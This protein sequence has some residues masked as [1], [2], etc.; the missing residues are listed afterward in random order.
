M[1]DSLKAV[2][3]ELVLTSVKDLKSKQFKVDRVI[4]AT[5]LD[6]E[7]AYPLSKNHRDI[8]EVFSYAENCFLNNQAFHDMG[9]R[10]QR[11]PFYWKERDFQDG[12]Y[13][14]YLSDYLDISYQ[15]AI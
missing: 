11:L 6:R 13:V 7:R 5:S 3:E 10:V 2:I 9:L 8:T 1:E 4:L 12:D 14:I 15:S